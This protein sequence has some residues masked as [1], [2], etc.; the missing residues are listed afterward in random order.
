MKTQRSADKADSGLIWR[1]NMP[2]AVPV[3]LGEQTFLNVLKIPERCSLSPGDPG[4]SHSAPLTPSPAAGMC[5]GAGMV[6]AETVWLSLG[7]AHHSLLI[8]CDEAVLQHPSVSPRG[9][10]EL[11]ASLHLPRTALE[12]GEQPGSLMA[13]AIG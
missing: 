4:A 7:A 11:T 2:Q 5:H 9:Q 1:G 10:A 6:C 13:F 3:G 12:Q 8:A